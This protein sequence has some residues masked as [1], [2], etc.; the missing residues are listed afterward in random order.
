MP[1]ILHVLDMLGWG[2]Y[3]Q[4]PNFRQPLS[5]V[6]VPVTGQGDISSIFLK[7]AI[8]AISPAAPSQGQQDGT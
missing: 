2:G 3:S 4:A 7:A 1:Q 8:A 6:A 5:H